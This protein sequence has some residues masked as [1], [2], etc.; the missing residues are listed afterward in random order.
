MLMSENQTNH[1]RKTYDLFDV[2]SDFGGLYI[3]VMAVLTFILAP[4][5]EFNFIV[6]AIQKLYNV[7]TKRQSIFRRSQSQKYIN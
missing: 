5:G 4:W 3:V 2:L 7:K 1:T 6:K